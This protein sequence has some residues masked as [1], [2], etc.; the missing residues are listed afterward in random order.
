MLL[1]KEQQEYDRLIN[2]LF[3]QY[4][5]CYVKSYNAQGY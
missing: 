3:Q 4:W 5:G 2:L 1:K